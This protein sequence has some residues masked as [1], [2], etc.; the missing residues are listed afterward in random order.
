MYVRI[1]VFTYIAPCSTPARV[2]GHVC[3]STVS[4]FSL[5]FCCDTLALSLNFGL[6]LFH[7]YFMICVFFFPCLYLLLWFFCW[8][9]LRRPSRTGGAASESAAEGP[10]GRTAK[11]EPP[12]WRLFHNRSY[13]LVPSYPLYFVVPAVM[14]DAHVRYVS[15]IQVSF[16]LPAR[17]LCLFCFCDWSY[18]RYMETLR[19]GAP[20]E[21]DY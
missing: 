8:F 2:K 13:G 4:F 20:I 17:F 9:S 14:G 5:L 15:Y 1:H 21:S 6:L 11:R 19:E 18:T 7:C 12:R 16:S 3:T 10:P